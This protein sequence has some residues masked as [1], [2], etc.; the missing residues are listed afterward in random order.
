MNSGAKNV[1]GGPVGHS[2]KWLALPD[3]RR[4]IRFLYPERS[5]EDD[6]AGS[7]FKRRNAATNTN[8]VVNPGGLKAGDSFTFEGTLLNLGTV[9]RK[10]KVG[11]YLS[12]NSTISTTDEYLNTT[13]LQLDPG[14]TTF[15]FNL[16]DSAVHKRWALF[17]RVCRRR[18]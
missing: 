15:T 2:K 6:V 14:V 5:Q 7:V 13:L 17:D 18:G 10:T 9:S 12:K 4:G 11:F 3:S 1:G 16:R 8:L